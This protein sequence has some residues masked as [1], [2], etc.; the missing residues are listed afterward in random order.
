MV[1]KIDLN[2]KNQGMWL[3]IRQYVNSVD[4]MENHLLELPLITPSIASSA[5]K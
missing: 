1:L 3:L 2:L 4:K 5:D